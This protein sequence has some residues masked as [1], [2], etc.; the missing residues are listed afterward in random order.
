LNQV[1][2]TASFADLIAAQIR[3]QLI[4]TSVDSVRIN[5]SV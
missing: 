5:T 3:V 2:L 4:A 1:W